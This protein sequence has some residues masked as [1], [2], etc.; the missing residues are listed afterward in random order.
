MID[1]RSCP[2]TE[3]NLLIVVADK[4]GAVIR[5]TIDISESGLRLAQHEAN[6]ALGQQ[7]RLTLGSVTGIS[8]ITNARVVRSDDDSVALRF[9]QTIDSATLAEVI[10]A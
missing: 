10:A 1:S 6:L 5:N 9:E 2:R 7:V 3:K 8:H 4:L